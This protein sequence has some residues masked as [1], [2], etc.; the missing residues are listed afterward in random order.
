MCVEVS[1]FCLLKR[2]LGILDYIKSRAINLISKSTTVNLQ[3]SARFKDLFS[4]YFNLNNSKISSWVSDCCDIYGKMLMKTEFELYDISG[5]EKREV[6]KHPILDIFKQPNPFQYWSEIKYNIGYHAG[7]YGESFLYKLRDALGIVRGILMLP[8]AAVQAVSIN[9]Y[10]DHYTVSFKSGLVDVPVNDMI[11][12]RYPNP[13]VKVAGKA[14]VSGILDTVE[15]DKLQTAYQKKFFEKG[16]F[17]GLTFSSDVNLSKD[18]FKEKAKLFSEKYGGLNNAFRVGLLDSGFKPINPS[19]TIK[20]MDISTQR[21]LTRDEILAA[22]Q[23]SKFQLG[24]GESINRA[25]AKENSMRF[26]GDVIEPLLYLYDDVLTYSLCVNEK[27][28]D[29]LAI[30]HENTSPR[31]LETDSLWYDTMTKNAAITPNEIRAYEDMEPIADT[32]MDLPITLQAKTVPQTQ[33]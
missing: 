28:W 2:E 22:F 3:E 13:D 23:I 5:E 27:G 31:D 18:T 29:W 17:M 30:K 32:R 15:V 19:H 14:I 21:N 26:A 24:M 20:D 6:E 12:L 1:P 11:H 10:L 9:S 25:T 4:D 7:I 33:N 16:G 8:N